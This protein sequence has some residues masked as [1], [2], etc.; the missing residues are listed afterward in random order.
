MQE[1]I[2]K[3]ERQQEEEKQEKAN[4]E[5]LKVPPTKR[6]SPLQDRHKRRKKQR[7]EHLHGPVTAPCVPPGP[8]EEEGR[9]TAPARGKR[10]HQCREHPDP[11]AEEGGGEAARHE[12]YGIHEREAGEFEPKF[13]RSQSRK[14]RAEVSERWPPLQEREAENDAEQKRGRKEKELEIARLRAQQER[15]KDYKAE[16]VSL[17]RRLVLSVWSSASVARHRT[18]TVHGDTR[19]AWTGNGGEKRRSWLQR[20][21]RRRRS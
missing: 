8:G 1:E 13:P 14:E 19:R 17:I 18:S 6:W 10:A 21:W 7:R 5:D 16:Q 20:K 3:L 2:Q 4:L 12:R 9:A 11:G 15:A